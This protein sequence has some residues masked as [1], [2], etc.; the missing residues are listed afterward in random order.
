MRLIIAEPARVIADHDDVVSVRAEDA[1]GSFGILPG[2]A[3]LITVMTPSV[4]AW[5]HVDGR[6]GWCAVRRGVL[7]VRDG[8][9]VA[10]ATRQAQLGNDLASLED[11]V[12][13][14]FRAE[15]DAER[16]AAF[17]W[18]PDA[19]GGVMTRKP[20]TEDNKLVSSIRLRST[21][22]QRAQRE[23]EPSF[24]RY[25]AQVGVLGWT[26]VVPTLLGV[27][28]GRWLDQR[29]GTGIFWTGP[30][31]IVGLAIGCWAAWRWMH[32]R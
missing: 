10:I 4:V 12:L 1:S 24:G 22:E 16:R 18:P 21:R 14:R 25:L 9:E 7:S 6:P 20:P 3:D 27:F 11:A 17:G 5:R 26:I 13:A 32:G 8:R 28:V 23:G 2:H 30:L 31:L 29:L 19:G 15:L